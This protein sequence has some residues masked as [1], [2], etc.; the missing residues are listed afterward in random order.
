M[1]PSRDDHAYIAW[2]IID[3]CLRE[4]V[5]GIVHRGS[6]ATPA[7]ALRQAWPGTSAPERW[8]RVPHL[9]AGPVWL[10]VRSSDYMQSLRATGDGWLRET[11][12]GGVYEHGADA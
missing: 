8:W 5:R 6:E 9:P 3:C 10:P 11:P 2:R 1:N 4:D 12:E 7:P